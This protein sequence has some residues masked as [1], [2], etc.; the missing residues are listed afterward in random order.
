MPLSDHA[1]S[2]PASLPEDVVAYRRTVEFDQDTM[3]AKMRNEHSTKPGVWALIHVLEGQLRYRVPSWS[4][5][6]I[7]S[8]GAPGIVAPEVVH[9][10]QPHGA[11]RMYVEFYAAPNQGP[12]DPHTSR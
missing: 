12:T 10:V 6:D 8:P 1:N 7:L 9:S 11:V 3:P 4:Y 5:D 2:R